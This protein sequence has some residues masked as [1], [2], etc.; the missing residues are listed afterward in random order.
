MKS[1]AERSR[2]RRVAAHPI[3]PSGLPTRQ[4]FGRLLSVA[5]HGMTASPD[6][7]LLIRTG[8]EQRLSDFL[9]WECAYAELLFTPRMWPEFTPADL[10]AALADFRLRD[11]RF[12]AVPEPAGPAAAARQLIGRSS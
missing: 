9:L 3:A 8:G 10:A 12:G 6:V 2:L 5:D 7:D 1:A 4:S 11:R